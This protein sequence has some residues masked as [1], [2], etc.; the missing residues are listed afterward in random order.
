MQGNPNDVAEILEQTSWLRSLARQLVRDPHTADDVVQSTIIAA[1]AWEEVPR[2]GLRNWLAGVARNMARQISRGER[3]RDRRHERAAVPEALPS[4]AAMAEVVETQ[5]TLAASVL[6][7]PEHYRQV[8]FLRYFEELTPSEIARRLDVP[9]STVRVRLMRGLDLLR[10][11]LQGEYAD[12]DRHWSLYLLPL[13]TPR[14]SGS[15]T[16]APLAG[17]AELSTITGGGVLKLALVSA[18]SAGAIALLWPEPED[19]SSPS[20]PAAV[21]SLDTTETRERVAPPVNLPPTRL[22][23]GRTAGAGAADAAEDALLAVE[24]GAIVGR[25]LDGSGAPVA[26]AE[27]WTIDGRRHAP[28][29]LELT[30]STPDLPVTRTLSDGS[31]RLEVHPDHPFLLRASAPGLA[32]AE[33]PRTFA[34]ER[35]DLTLTTGGSL[36]LVAVDAATR[37]QIAGARLR[38]ASVHPHAVPTAWTREGL[39]DDDGRVRFE[40]LPAGSIKIT[41]VR[42]GFAHQEWQSE[43]DG[44]SDS[45]QEL[46]LPEAT[47]VRGVVL[48]KDSEVPVANARV[49]GPSGETATDAL[50][51]FELTGLPRGE[52]RPIGIVVWAQGHEPSA[53]Y[54]RLSTVGDQPYVTFELVPPTIVTGRVVDSF[55]RPLVGVEV[56]YRGRF[57]HVPGKQERQ[58]GSVRTDADGRF[59]MELHHRAAYTIGAEADGLPLVITRVNTERDGDSPIDVGEFVLAKGARVSG[60]V[61]GRAYDRERPDTLEFSRIAYG[62][63]SILSA[64]LTLLVVPVQPNG[65]FE[66]A[67]IAPGRY[68]ITLHTPHPDGSSKELVL[69]RRR[70]ELAEGQTLENVEL[71]PIEPIQGRITLADGSPVHRATVELRA[72]SAGEPLVRALTDRDGRYELRPPPG[73]SWT[74]APIDPDQLREGRLREDVDAGTTNVDFVLRDRATPHSLSGRVV[75]ELGH[76]IAGVEIRLTDEGTRMLLRRRGETDADG[77]FELKNLDESTFTVRAVDPQTLHKS[78][79]QRSVST[80]EEPIELR[81][82]SLD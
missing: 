82:E 35:R 17:G 70:I 76:P 67:S 16:P 72:N 24:D 21:L 14:S 19:S 62:D 41:A 32:G 54:V 4:T 51:R 28:E 79:A 8:V 52:D 5:R 48:V 7:L 31:F 45:A 78:A 30:P 2:E 40:A 66:A 13:A 11:R 77:R 33:S 6:D 50:G 27:V 73:S 18:V 9:A 36:V 81:L 3:R 46:G 55:R 26:G 20:G 60:R 71:T 38:I 68:E 58:D 59:H 56:G 22:G 74:L 37:E 69:A 42:D 64:P 44:H 57:M 29:V 1:L 39:T 25:V 80:G 34:G 10:D 47:S 23:D 12:A 65:R 43:L 63:N 15:G 49:V 61:H 53:A 75:D